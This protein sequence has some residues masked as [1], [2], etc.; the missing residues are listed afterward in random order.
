MKKA[1]IT[2]VTGQDGSYLSEFLLNKNYIVY[3]IKRKSSSLNTDRIDHIYSNNKFKNKFFLIYGDLTDVNSIS[4]IIS[5]IKPDEIYNLAAQSH[6]GVSFELPYYT[7]QVNAIGTLNIL[8]AIRANEL[9]SKTRFYQASTS[10]LFGE[11]QD[12]KQSEKT[13]FY[14]KS[15]YATSKLFGYWIT[16]NYRESYNMHASNGILFNHESPRRGETFV[17][18]KITRGISKIILGIEDHIKLGNIYSL[19]DW[20]HARDYVEM[21]WKIVQHKKADDFIVAT[22]KQHTV[23]IFIEKC[24]KYLDIKI[25]WSG[26]GINETATIVKYDQDRYPNLKKNMKVIKIDKKYF[27]PN[28]VENLIGDFSK[29]KK[30]LNWKPKTSINDLIKEMIDSDMSE[31]KK[32]LK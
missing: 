4:S 12:K 1:L 19:R 13:K 21:C 22:G 11:I 5:K 7:A 18:R 24:F 31:S 6:V 20:G 3:G 23:K 26:S 16:K 14:P 30:T 17:T 8:E 10:E 25:K 28:E 27:R 32:L 2:G 9:Q 29:S 15:P